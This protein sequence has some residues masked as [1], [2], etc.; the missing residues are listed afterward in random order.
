MTGKKA[1]SIVKELKT[2]VKELKKR[3]DLK[4]QK[5]TFGKR[6][7]KLELARVRELSPELADLY[8]CV[9]GIDIEWSFIEAPN[10]GGRLRIPPAE[11]AR[12]Q[13]E[14]ETRM[15]FGATKDALLLDDQDS[16]ATWL[17]RDSKGKCQLL[18]AAPAEGADAV[19]PA[20]SLNDYLEAAIS[21]GFITNWPF[22]N[23]GP[24]LSISVDSERA[25]R[26]RFQ[27]PPVKPAKLRAG[28]RVHSE[29]ARGE[30]KSVVHPP[31]S[32]PDDLWSFVDG[33]LFEVQFDD[34]LLAWVPQ[35]SI[36]P[37]KAS[38]DLYEELI[39]P[40][41]I[42]P[43]DSKESVLESM[44]KLARAGGP[45]GDSNYVQGVGSVSGNAWIVAGLFAKRSPVQVCKLLTDLAQAAD[46]YGVDLNSS[47]D[48]DKAGVYSAKPWKSCRWKFKLKEVFDG[49]LCGLQLRVVRES[50]NTQKSPADLISKSVR[51]ALKAVP[52]TIHIGESTQEMLGKKAV[53]EWPEWDHKSE[54]ATALGLPE[55]SIV[56]PGGRS[57]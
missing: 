47:R 56:F 51:D 48:M 36:K 20:S 49:L 10:A 5:A 8:Q 57:F 13:G 17:V 28:I 50:S 39:E 45:A 16:S 15:G 27:A 26:E 42:I 46:K 11:F 55:Q 35:R 7:K 22:L 43:C 34:G 3:P 9:D 53:L 19:V 44:D 30:I 18:F 2:F 1:D 32:S 12:F 21:S 14:D 37:V 52:C 23:E 24:P 31:K 4:V 25:A 33:P 54:H 6:A 40:S 41:Q 29:A 38:A